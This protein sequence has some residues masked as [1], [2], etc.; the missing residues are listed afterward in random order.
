MVP[1][2]PSHGCGDRD[3]AAALRAKDAEQ[4]ALLQRAAVRV[5]NAGG[6]PERV[7]T[8]G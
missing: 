3:E 8:G 1:G 6:E 2:P 5:G 4:T 7:G